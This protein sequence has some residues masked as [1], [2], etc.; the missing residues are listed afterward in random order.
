[1]KIG[2]DARWIFPEISGIGT[3]TQELLK[4]LVCL[5]TSNEYVLFFNDPETMERERELIGLNHAPNFSSKLLTYGLFSPH[6]LVLMPGLLKRLRLDVFHSPNYMVPLLAFPRGRA[7][8]PRCLVTIHDMIPLLFPELTP[9]AL[10]TRL[11]P[12]FRRLMAEV[13]ARAD[14]ILTVSSSSRTDV[15]QQLKIPPN[16][17]DRV[18]VIPNGVAAEYKPS[19]RKP[20]EIK[21]VLYVGRFDPYKNVPGMLETFARVR[22][23]CPFEV[24][25]KIVGPPD[26]RYPEAPRLA[27]E[28]GLNRWI[29]WAGYR[30][31]P[32][33]VRE[34]QEADVL[35]LQSKYEGFGLTVLEAMACGTPVVCSNRSSLPEVAG[36]AALL[37]NP[38]NTREA[39]AAVARVLQDQAL[40]A[41]LA[42]KGLQQAAK[43]T[44]TRTAAMTLKAYEHSLDLA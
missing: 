7:A 10:K 18:I 36:E 17:Q 14:L 3:Y 24:R 19:A 44:W 21:T 42:E 1:M 13:G 23:L 4:N 9:K 29:D 5:D 35:L 25:L 30:S 40:A 26:P 12:L 43:F 2:I 22:D 20:R 16:R 33:L 31:G 37:V 38:D 41:G 28:R 39:A 6:G 34:Y 27:D 8:R 15:I 32:D 11:L